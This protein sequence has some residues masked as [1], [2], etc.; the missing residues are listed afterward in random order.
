MIRISVNSKAINRLVRILCSIIVLIINLPSSHAQNQPNIV[1]ILADDMGYSDVGCYGSEIETPNIDRLAKDGLQFTQFYSAGRC[2]PSR[3]TLLTGLYP[4]M[5]GM[6]WMTGVDM[7]EPGYPGDLNDQCATVAEVL[8]TAGYGT[9]ATGK[10]HVSENVKY[11]GEKH[12]WPLQRGFDQYYGIIPGAANYFEPVG[13]TYGNDPAEAVGDFYLT[14]AISDTS[15][16]FIQRHIRQNRESPFLLYVAYNAPHWPLHAKENDIRKYLDTYKKG[17]DKIRQERYERQLKTGWLEKAV[18]LSERDAEVPAWE[19]IPEQD[20]ELWIK[21]MA[22]YAAQ[23]DCMDQGIGRIVGT[24]KEN[25]IYENTLLIFLSDNGASAER[26]SRGD[27]SVEILGQK[28]SYESYLIPWANVS[29]T[30]LRWFKSNMHEGGIA[31]PCVISW[32]KGIEKNGAFET[33][34]AHFIDLMPTFIELSGAHYPDFLNEQKL[35][36]LPGKSLVGVFK[37]EKLENR[38]LFWEH[39][40]NRAVRRGKWKLVSNGNPDTPYVGSWELY[41]ITKDRTEM[42]DMAST[43]PEIVQE[44]EKLWNEWAEKNRV[45]P[46]NGTNIPTRF[47]TFGRKK[48]GYFE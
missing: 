5:A 16:Q 39:E 27:K 42:Q 41:D 21:R 31:S 38:P 7:L 40:A 37:G 4:H 3:A 48:T 1:I 28:E 19:E 20:K 10:W 18:K 9:Y 22:V 32:P 14:D 23:I 2:C 8:K 11:E 46:L 34:P 30:P 36:P 44:M 24:L 25:G 45:F 15:V 35:P 47:K 33:T 43:H 17:W 13:L 6:G 26:V 29:N 12:N